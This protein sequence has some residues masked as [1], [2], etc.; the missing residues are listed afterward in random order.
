MNREELAATYGDDLLFLDPPE[1]FDEC[2]LGAVYRCTAEPV[3]CY[4]Q[5][6]V[7]EALMRS[8]MDEDEAAEFFDFNI[9]CAYVGPRTPMFLERPEC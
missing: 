5:Q 1:Q 8:G 2:I 4:D 3:V 9:A 6:K 7:I